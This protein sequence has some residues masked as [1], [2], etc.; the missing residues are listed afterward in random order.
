[1][2]DVGPSIREGCAL[3]HARHKPPM[4]TAIQWSLAREL[5]EVTAGAH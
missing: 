4:R 3:H 1:M 2:R 5:R